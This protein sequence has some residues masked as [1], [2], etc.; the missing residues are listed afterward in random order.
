MIYTV[1]LKKGT[2]VDYLPPTIR[3]ASSVEL[4]DVTDTPL[5]VHRPGLLLSII[6]LVGTSGGISEARFKSVK[7]KKH[8]A[9]SLHQPEQRKNQHS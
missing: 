2:T 5:W 6:P 1:L 3:G 4:R 7:N 9:S 8:E